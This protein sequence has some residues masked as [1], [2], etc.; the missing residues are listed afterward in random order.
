MLD[1]HIARTE[2]TPQNAMTTNQTNNR[3]ALPV[4]DDLQ[5]IMLNAPRKKRV[6]SQYSA[7]ANLAFTFALMTILYFRRRRNEHNEN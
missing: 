3:I 7:M 6:T 4:C 5:Y 2:L 1:D